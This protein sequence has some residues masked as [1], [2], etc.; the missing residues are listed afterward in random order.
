MS[1]E[2]ILHLL[3]EEDRSVPEAVAAALGEIARVATMAAEALSGSGRLVYVGAGTSGR[4]GVLDAAEC[5][6]TFGIA[7]DRVV[8]LMAGGPEA[9]FRAREGAEDDAAA[10][11]RDAE[12]LRPGVA[13]L[14][15][16]I[17]A[18]GVTPYV[19]AALAAARAAG[20]RTAF[21]TCGDARGV[22]AD[23]VVRLETGPEVL[24][25]STRLKAG[26]ATKLVLNMISTAAMVR[27]GKVY[28]DLMVDLR[29]A[30]AKL[31]DRAR[32]L[33]TLLTGR[34]G[35]EA[36]ALLASADGEVKTA[37]V[38]DRRQVPVAEARA[39]LARVGG[40]L[41]EALG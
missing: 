31:E 36:G 1:T 25:G 15:V 21:L 24:A 11:A 32:R 12:A 13:D 33:V 19:R 9:V 14:F 7:P 22:A 18:S 16:G 30:S 26:T 39:L 10:G 28:G 5:P 29:A 34:E 23:T 6:P 2:Q 40:S 38:M 35:A 20:A 3:N 8:A 27:A 41:R 4:L 17:A 37:V